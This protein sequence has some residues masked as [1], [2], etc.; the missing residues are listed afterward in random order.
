M[1]ACK[2]PRGGGIVPFASPD[3]EEGRSVVFEIQ[4]S[5]MSQQ[6]VGWQLFERDADIPEEILD[7]VPSLDELLDVP[8]YEEVKRA[9]WA[10]LDVAK[11]ELTY[12]EEYFDDT[13]VKT[14]GCPFG[15]TIGVDFGNYEEC[16]ECPAYNDCRD[17]HQHLAQPEEEDVEEEAKDIPLPS[18]QHPKLRSV[19]TSPQ[20]TRRRRTQE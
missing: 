15:S 11:E 4:G 19:E 18:P 2:R 20:P 3:K 13:P 7:K 5:K 6:Y 16:D 9:F 17:L 8:T 12:E 14:V 1:S 10:G